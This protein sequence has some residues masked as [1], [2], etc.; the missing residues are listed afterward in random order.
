[1]PPS[2]L[3]C[4]YSAR[5]ARKPPAVDRHQRK[6][7]DDESANG[8]GAHCRVRPLP[9]GRGLLYEAATVILTRSKAESDLRSW[10]LR[11][12]E[13]IGFKRAAN[14]VAR[15]LAVIMHAM[16]RSGEL[17]NARPPQP[18]NSSSASRGVTR[19][20]CRD[21][22]W[23]IPQSAMHLELRLR[24][25]RLKH[26]KGRPRPRS[27]IMRGLMP[28]AKTTMLLANSPQQSACITGRN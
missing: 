15:K 25:M 16:L 22:G 20:P 21:V 10:G 24:S 6:P 28:A 1:M 23:P 12:R 4:F 8:A 11:L 17:F 13:K 5:L 7:G 9:H 14:A 3:A 26:R 2:A 19:R 18:D 27:P